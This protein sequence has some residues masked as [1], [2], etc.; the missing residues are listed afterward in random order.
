MTIGSSKSSKA[1]ASAFLTLTSKDL[2]P[3][4]VPST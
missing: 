2:P 1:K 3:P 4:D